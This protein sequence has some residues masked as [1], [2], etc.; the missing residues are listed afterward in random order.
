[1][2]SEIVSVLSKNN[3][4]AELETVSLLLGLFKKYDIRDYI[5][6]DNVV[7]QTGVIPHSH[8]VLTVNTRHNKNEHRLLLCFLHE[9][10][11]WFAEENGSRV[12]MAIEELRKTFPN[13]PKSPPEGARNEFSSYLHLI[14]NLLELLAAKKYLGDNRAYEIIAKM[15]VYPG[16][17]KTVLTEEG[18]IEK[19]L[20]R[21]SLII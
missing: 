19:I 15:D 9:Q 12:K 4:E 2:A 18:K 21:H 1:M 14:I 3:T 20:R 13:I 17:Y 11:H 8:P 7:V 5:F 16:I 10:I 6:T